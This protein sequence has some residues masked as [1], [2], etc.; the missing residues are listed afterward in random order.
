MG[1]S[2][3]SSIQNEHYVSPSMSKKELEANT[4]SPVRGDK[5][6]NGE[7]L[8]YYKDISILRVEKNKTFVINICKDTS[9]F[10]IKYSEGFLFINKLPL[11]INCLAYTENNLLC[12]DSTFFVRTSDLATIWFEERTTTHLYFWANLGYFEHHY[13][14]LYVMGVGESIIF[15]PVN[16][17]EYELLEED[18]PNVYF[19]KSRLKPAFKKYFLVGFKDKQCAIFEEII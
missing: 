4:V 12:F 13:D 14:E 9:Y 15:L 2:L 16:Y 6:C 11:G 5:I 8:K 10:K 19:L 7:I 18:D 1:K 3:L 17:I